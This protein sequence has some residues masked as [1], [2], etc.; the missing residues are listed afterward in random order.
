M[1]DP[2]H[3]T[4]N[5]HR[6]AQYAQLAM[7]LEVCATPKPGNVDR[8][9][10]YPD[11]R[12]EHFLA[13]AVSVYPVV[14]MAS[15][16]YMGIGRYIHEAVLE[17]G[18]WQ[19]G[20]NTHFGAFLLLMPLVMAAGKLENKNQNTPAIF[21]ELKRM[22]V[23]LVQN[24]TVDD[25]VEVYRAFSKA[26]VKVKDVSELDLNDPASIDNIR[27][28]GTTLYQLMEISSSYDMI[29]REWTGGFPLTF[30]CASSILGKKEQICL[31]DAVVWS[32]LE[33]LAR[34]PDTFIRIKFDGPMA[35]K[36]SARAKDIIGTIEVSGFDNA[37]DDIRTFDEEL[38]RDGINPGSTADI[39]IAGLFVA[40]MGGLEV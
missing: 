22:T 7:I 29:A 40:L 11:T 34:N 14:E 39:I 37:K 24:T 35:E 12:L 33:I 19:L 8:D 17:S 25:A 1:P 6:I 18:K 30:S 21:P 36:V 32:F 3:I 28:N 10:N 26:G 9:H 38:I 16:D 23:E 2:V 13:S 4:Y 27:S 31:N 5:D 20:G 15:Q